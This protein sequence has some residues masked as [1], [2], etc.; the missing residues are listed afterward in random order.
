MNLHPSWLT[1][2][3]APELATLT[4][5]DVVLDVACTALLAA[6]PELGASRPT[7]IVPAPTSL[8]LAEVIIEATTTLRVYLDRYDVAVRRERHVSAP[9]D[10]MPG[11]PIYAR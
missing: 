11:D 5:L 9:E 3:E 1:V 2:A 10:G 6:H 4:A 7:E 8:W